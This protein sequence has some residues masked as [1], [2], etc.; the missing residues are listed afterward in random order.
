M[1]RGIDSFRVGAGVGSWVGSVGCLEGLRDGAFD[2]KAHH[3]VGSDVGTGA[4]VGDGVGSG[5]VSISL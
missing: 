3:V 1:G 4:A 5:A 2:F